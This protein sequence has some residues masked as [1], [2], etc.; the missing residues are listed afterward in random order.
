MSGIR[1]EVPRALVVELLNLRICSPIV[2]AAVKAVYS[3]LLASRLEI[4]F[5]NKETTL[6]NERTVEKYYR[7][8]VYIIAL[9]FCLLGVCPYVL[10]RGEVRGDH[11]PKRVRD[12]V[13]PSR[14]ARVPAYAVPEPE[15]YS[16][17]VEIDSKGEMHTTAK[18]IKDGVDV[19]VCRSQM[20][21]GPLVSGLFDSIGGAPAPR[22]RGTDAARRAAA[23]LPRALRA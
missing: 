16:L 5:K 21:K 22:A 7:R 6:T 15:A 14:V 17:I 18:G 1:Y 3:G 4:N 12:F 20:F 11:D 8:A 9:H 2:A 23:E 19:R 13:V 10:I